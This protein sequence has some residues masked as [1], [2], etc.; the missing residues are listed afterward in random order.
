M[1]MVGLSSCMP[2]QAS[3]DYSDRFTQSTDENRAVSATGEA[4]DTQDVLGTL[5]HMLGAPDQYDVVTAMNI[6][7]IRDLDELNESIYDTY[8]LRIADNMKIETNYKDSLPIR[9]KV[10]D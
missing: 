7:F 4:L 8:T 3:V 6:R 1:A 10:E 9:S 5:S 2:Q